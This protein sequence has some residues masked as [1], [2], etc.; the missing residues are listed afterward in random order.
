MS[1]NSGD[2]YNKTSIT[3]ENKRNYDEEVTELTKYIQEL[4]F[5]QEKSR[6]DLNRDRE[7]LR[8][9][10]EEI[11]KKESFIRS[12]EKRIS[13]C[14]VKLNRFLT[15]RRIVEERR[16][17]QKIATPY[18]ISSF[19]GRGTTNLFVGD[20]VYTND[21]QGVFKGKFIATVVSLPKQKNRVTLKFDGVNETTTRDIKFLRHAN[22]H[23]N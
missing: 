16:G 10:K 15:S 17:Q 4:N 8:K 23:H 1:S 3:R 13:S 19:D 18:R 5:K 6:R 9:L 7:S 11:V 22:R 2:P 21:G 14:K 12:N 20:R